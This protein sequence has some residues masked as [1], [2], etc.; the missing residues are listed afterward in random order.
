M[1]PSEPIDLIITCDVHKFV[2]TL[3]Q[4]F[5]AN[6][7]MDVAVVVLF[8]CLPL[9]MIFSSISF[10]KTHLNLFE[11]IAIC[12]VWFVHENC[13]AESV[14]RVKWPKVLIK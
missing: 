1:S 6:A 5:E 14:K 2:V 11:L 3:E 10:F 8:D 4:M 13:V 12:C 7:V 9:E